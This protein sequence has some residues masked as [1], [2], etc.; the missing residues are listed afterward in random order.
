MPVR[1]IQR[2]EAIIGAHERELD[3]R[4][5]VISDQAD[6]IAYLERRGAQADE[7]AVSGRVGVYLVER[8]AGPA[9]RIVR[10]SDR[11]EAFRVEDFGDLTQEEFWRFI[12]L[13]RVAQ[14]DHFEFKTG[15]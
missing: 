11:D 5:N 15:G 1:E 12:E 6:R 4:A 2:L 14:V 8:D 13:G 3:H 9:A 7:L 10:R